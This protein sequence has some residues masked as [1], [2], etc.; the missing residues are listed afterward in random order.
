MDWTTRV[1][2]LSIL[3]RFD[4]SPN[5]R[6]YKRH[7]F[8]RSKPSFSSLLLA[9]LLFVRPDHKF[10]GFCNARP[11]LIATTVPFA[12]E[13]TS[14]SLLKVYLDI[15]PGNQCNK[16]YFSNDDPQLKFGITA[17]SMICAGSAEG[18]KDTCVV[19]TNAYTRLFGCR[20][21]ENS[22]RS[23]IINIGVSGRFRGSASSEKRLQFGYV[24]AIRYYVVRQVLRRQEY[25]RRVHQSVEVR[26]VD[27]RDRMA[28]IVWNS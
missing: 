15:V 7:F 21:W 28:E 2:R 9:F 13:T 20:R 16:S 4:I 22:R 24:H 12:D 19:R 6:V 17:D 23:D 25:A 18:D 1:F 11:P 14:N 8:S 3:A 5:V 27:R 26:S 10:P